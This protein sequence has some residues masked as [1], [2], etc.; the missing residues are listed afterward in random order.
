VLTAGKETFQLTPKTNRQKMLKRTVAIYA[1]QKQI[2]AFPLSP[3]APLNALAKQSSSST[4][5]Q[6]Q[7]WSLSRRIWL[8]D[9]VCTPP[10]DHTSQH[11]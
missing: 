7:R 8:Q 5:L 9:H 3:I 2:V 6:P 11:R 10:V 1:Y 4:N